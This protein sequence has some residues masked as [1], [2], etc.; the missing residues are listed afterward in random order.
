MRRGEGREEHHLGKVVPEFAEPHQE[1][2]SAYGKPSKQRRKSISIES[3]AATGTLRACAARPIA[4][5]VTSR[6]PAGTVM[7][8]CPSAAVLLGV[9]STCTWASGRGDPSSLKT[10]PVSTPP[11]VSRL[12]RRR[13]RVD[14]LALHR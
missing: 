2:V 14:T 13:T 7:A 8:K 5:A 1:H 6:L 9:P 3:P 10:W 11:G 12:E 4:V